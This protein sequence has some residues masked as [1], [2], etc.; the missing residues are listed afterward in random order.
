M[1]FTA[2]YDANVL[3]PAGMRDL[4]VRLG[5]SGLFRARWTHQIL[6]EMA[7]SILRNRPDLESDRL[8]RTS[9]LMCEAIADCLVTGY[10]P[11]IEGLTLPDPDD[12]HVLAAAIRCS[13]Q[14][15]VTT[16]LSDFPATAL[17]PF[18]IEAQH[19]DQFVL[20]LVNLAPARVATVVQQQA[21]AL[22]NPAR[23]VHELFEDLSNSGL[24]RAVAALR[25]LFEG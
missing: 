4:L 19:P 7:R 10:E 15:I 2:L 8:A 11:L 3:H 1:A 14:V 21:A 23:T 13:A 18:N 20:D 6:D 25:A 9:Q 22:Q 16:N 24:P 17:E 12:R 5:Q